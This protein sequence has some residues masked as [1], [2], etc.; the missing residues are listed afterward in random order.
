MYIDVHMECLGSQQDEACR[1]LPDRGLM[2]DVEVKD[3]EKQGL[4]CKCS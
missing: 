4:S 1:L 2:V 3:E